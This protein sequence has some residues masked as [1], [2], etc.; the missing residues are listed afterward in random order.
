MATFP[1]FW[2]RNMVS[3]GR[4]KIVVFIRKDYSFFFW[5]HRE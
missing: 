5:L 4:K 3:F 1:E 2:V